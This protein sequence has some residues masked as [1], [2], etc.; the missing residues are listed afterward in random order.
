MAS[1]F[2]GMDPYLEQADVWPGFHGQ[3]LSAIVAQLVPQVTP[4]Y[5]VRMKE[6]LF[7][8]EL[9]AEERRFLGRADVAVGVGTS[10]KA[11]SQTTSS[12]L[13]A[14]VE[15]RLPAV[16]IERHRSIEIR[17][18]RSRSLVTV[19]ELLSPS[20]KKPGPDREQYLAKRGVIQA[21]PAH[22]LEIDLLRC[23]APL[24]TLDPRP[25]CT[26]SVLISRSEKWPRAD[27]WPITL[28]DRLPVVPVPLHT[29]EPDATLD[30][31]SVLTRAYDEGGFAFSIYEGEPEPPLDKDDSAWA[32][33]ILKAR[34]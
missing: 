21:S 34:A 10:T 23:R 11:T 9:P 19:I 17:D 6:Q 12:L 2:P 16:D 31:Q 3:A 20:N 1:P 15:V 28:R 14:P 7:I 13:A 29:G 22:L 8:H 30:L 33:E 32:Q 18:R 25:E 27:F 4:A 5:V 24:P 26:Y